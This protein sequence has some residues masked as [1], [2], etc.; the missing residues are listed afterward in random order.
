MLEISK[1]LTI[2][3]A[4]R[5]K[6]KL[7]GD[8]FANFHSPGPQAWRSPLLDFKGVKTPRLEKILVDIYCDDDLDYLHGNEWSRMFDNALSMY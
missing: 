1:D 5:D 3:Y 8:N 4:D 2:E 6:W 7:T